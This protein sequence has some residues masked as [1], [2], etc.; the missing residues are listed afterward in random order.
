M[1]LTGRD[2]KALLVGSGIL[3]V[4]CLLQFLVFPL[5]D[6]RERAI[7]AISSKE[8][9][10]VEMEEMIAK[11][12]VLGQ[13]NN[14]L[15]RILDQRDNK[16]SLFSFLESNA[17]KSKVKNHIN[18]MKPSEI[19]G[20]GALKQSLVE[21]K[22]RAI[23]ITQLVTFLELTESS[24][25][26]VGIKRISIQENTKQKGTLDVILQIVSIDSISGAER[27]VQ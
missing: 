20:D 14:S 9:Q 18:Y 8:K 6:K 13:Q 25:N 19:S 17:A 22:F 5:V 27:G 12:K 16:F 4:Y 11:Y 3:L 26:L 23:S 24:E 1:Q 2:R 10:L 15:A 21:M 7:K